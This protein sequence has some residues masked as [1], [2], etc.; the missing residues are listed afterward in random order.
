MKR[1]LLF[2]ALASAIIGCTSN[3]S[4]TET[5]KTDTTTTTAATTAATATTAP[6][7]AL[8]SATKMKNMMDYMTPG[9]MQKMLASMNGKWTTEVTMAMPGGEQKSTGS[10][11][12]KMIMGGRFQQMSYKGTMMGQPF[13]GSGLLGY[14]NLRKV[15]TNSWID[16]MGTAVTYME[17]PYDE[18]SKTISLKGKCTDPETGRV[19]EMRQTMKLV[20]DKNQLV[21]MFMTPE[22]G[23]ETKLMEI[24]A[25]HK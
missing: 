13:E 6:P 10:I 21:E 11:E 8:D 7:P 1:T 18:A 12:Y 20:D 23:T 4:K 14:D 2:F 16:N 24:K 3:E 5:T 19:G 22:G 15:F 9:D 25:V 17:G